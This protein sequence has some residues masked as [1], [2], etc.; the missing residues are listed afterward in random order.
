MVPITAAVSRKRRNAAIAATR[1]SRVRC[2]IGQPGAEA[3]S[4]NPGCPS[5]R[6]R[7]IHAAI[8]RVEITLDP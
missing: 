4:L 2:G 6:Q 5:A 1:S 7:A 8:V 3:R